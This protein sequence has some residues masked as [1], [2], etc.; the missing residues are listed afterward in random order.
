MSSCTTRVC[1]RGAGVEE[2]SRWLKPRHPAI[3]S[4]F[5][6]PH[7]APTVPLRGAPVPRLRRF[8]A[9]W[10]DFALFFWRMLHA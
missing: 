9:K 5:P 2:D 7:Q 8:G 6:Q 3:T 4:R 1:T 10:C